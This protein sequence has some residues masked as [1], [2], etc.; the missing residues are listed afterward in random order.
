[1]ISFD[2]HPWVYNYTT[3]QDRYS[4]HVK[5][6]KDQII[7]EVS[8]PGI[9]K[10]ELELDYHGD[11]LKLHIFVKDKVDKDI[12][13]TVAIDEE[14]IKAELDLGVLKITAP[15]LNSSKRIQIK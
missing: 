9:K 7:A 11:K 13:F 12:W 5:E 6:E 10:E 3:F 15:V 2:I 8:L 14:N 1:M 4:F